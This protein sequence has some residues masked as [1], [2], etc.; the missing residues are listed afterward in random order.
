MKRKILATGVLSIL[1]LTSLLLTISAQQMVRMDAGKL[2]PKVEKALE[3]IRRNLIEVKSEM[4]GMACCIGPA[5]TFCPLVAGKCP[6]GLNVRS[7]SGVCGE[8][9]DG[10]H[11][12]QG[13][14]QGVKAADVKHWNATMLDSM[15]KA[16]ASIFSKAQKPVGAPK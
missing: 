10:W 2:S 14:I 16:R 6:C 13:R 12:G 11:A 8:C 9:Y 3:D 1:L 5:C 7:E 15:F 4:P